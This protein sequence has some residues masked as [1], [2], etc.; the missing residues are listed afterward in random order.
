MVRFST[1][2]LAAMVVALIAGTVTAIPPRTPQQEQAYRLLREKKFAE[3]VEVFAPLVRDNPYA[4]DLFA[5]R[6]TVSYGPPNIKIL[7]I[8][9]C[10][11]LRFDGLIL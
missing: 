3:S 7:I 8:N 4:G 5:A 1:S 11:D 2:L 9:F 10:I 6:S